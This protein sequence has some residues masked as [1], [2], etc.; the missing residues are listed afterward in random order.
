MILCGSNQK[1]VTAEYA[2][3]DL[4]KPIGIAKYRLTDAIPEHLRTALPSIEEL[5]AKLRKDRE[6]AQDQG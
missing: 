4:N 5:E 3:R 2:L 1:K 6:Q